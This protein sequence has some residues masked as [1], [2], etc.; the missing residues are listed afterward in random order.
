MR[1]RQSS[2]RLR[3]SLTDIVFA[4]LKEKIFNGMKMSLITGAKL[5]L[6]QV[7]GDRDALVLQLH[8]HLT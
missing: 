5:C 7:Q 4:T 6:V 2:P 1:R 3:G 8:F